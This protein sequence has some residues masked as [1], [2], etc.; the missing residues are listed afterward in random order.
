MAEPQVRR[1]ELPSFGPD[2]TGYSILRKNGVVNGLG[3]R[4]A[5]FG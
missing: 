5:L 4:Y 2:R 1:L 3:T